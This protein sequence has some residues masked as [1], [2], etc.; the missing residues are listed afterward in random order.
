MTACCVWNASNAAVSS[1]GVAPTTSALANG[2]T[3][4]S[5][6]V[7]P[8]YAGVKFDADGEEYESSAAGGWGT[9]VGTWLDTGV[10]GDVWVEFIRTSGTKTAFIGKSDSTRYN[11]VTDNIFRISD[12]S[13]GAAYENI[14]G[15][16][17]FWDAASG[18][19]LL[20]TTSL[21]DWRCRR[22]VDPCPLCC[23]TPDTPITMGDGS[24]MH[25]AD[26]RVGDM[27]MVVD[28]VEAVTEVITR[29]DRDMFDITF[30]DGRVLTA[31]DDHPLYVEGKGF[32]AINPDPSI[33][34]KDLG[35]AEILTTG[36]MV[37]DQD[38]NLNEVL[39]IQQVEFP[40]TV[41]TFGNT[42]FYANGMLVY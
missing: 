11:N 7:N 40:E 12:S 25:I 28:G 29:T 14:Y 22:A 8:V 33:S 30:L 9:T 36:D 35:V 10:P 16:F 31:S 26:I 15:L 18:G 38:H 4:S 1:G 42:R 3:N 19:S 34:Y 39:T 32:A 37:L 13:A 24:T 17:K 21:A 41:Y 6:L 20:Q 27:I 5:Y 23:F 2:D